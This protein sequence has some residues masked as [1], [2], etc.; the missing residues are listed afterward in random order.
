MRDEFKKNKARKKKESQLTFR[1]LLFS[2]LVM[3]MFGV[4]VYGLFDL[5]IVKGAD[6]AAQTGKESIKTI[7]IKGDSA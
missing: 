3:A 4:L 2:A 6:Y 5:Q 1:F 7:P